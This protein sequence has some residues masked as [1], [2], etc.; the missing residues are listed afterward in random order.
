LI[1]EAK[2]DVQNPAGQNRETALYL[3]EEVGK[4]TGGQ[5][6][7]TVANQRNRVKRIIGLYGKYSG[8]QSPVRHYH[9]KNLKAFHTRTRLSRP[10]NH[11]HHLLHCFREAVPTAGLLR[12]M[13]RVMFLKHTSCSSSKG[14]PSSNSNPHD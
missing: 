9:A 2:P 3:L 6:G 11:P 10:A 8:S 4:K 1:S 7:G 12:R 14:P 13:H 5:T